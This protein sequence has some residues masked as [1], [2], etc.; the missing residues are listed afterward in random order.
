MDEQ[1]TIEIFVAYSRKDKNSLL[2]LKTSLSPLERNNSI[3]LWCDGEIVPGEDWQ[4]EIRDAI[5]RSE[6]IL[7]LVSANSIASDYFYKKE[8]ANAMER[9]NKKESK[10]IPV[11]LKPCGWRD[12]FLKNLQALPKNGKPIILWNRVDEAYQSIYEGL[13]LAIKQVREERF[14]KNR[15]VEETTNDE[16]KKLQAEPDAPYS[17]VLKP[18][19]LKKTKNLKS[20]SPINKVIN[21]K[22]SENEKK[23]KVM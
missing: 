23:I 4:N 9:H 8:V 7:L 1:K 13:K 20:K 6:I 12:S 22:H 3:R 11:I 21:T 5:D 18:D 2:K 17:N 15:T 16:N 10:V 19:L 14:L